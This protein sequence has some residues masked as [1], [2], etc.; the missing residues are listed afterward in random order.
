MALGAPGTGSAPGAG[1]APRPPRDHARES[2][3]IAGAA[4]ASGVVVA[5]PAHGSDVSRIV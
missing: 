1:T 3:E 2:S 5:E 4:Y